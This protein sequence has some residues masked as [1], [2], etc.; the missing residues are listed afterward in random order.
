M[1]LVAAILLVGGCTTTYTASNGML[2]YG[3][4]R[5][6]EVGEIKATDGYIYLIHPE[7]MTFGGKPWQNLEDLIEPELSRAGGDSVTNL[8]ITDGYTIV[9]FILTGITGGILGFRH[10]SVSGTALN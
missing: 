2:G 4:M 6:S 3:E 7:L 9:D 10:I 5:G 1:A 8:E